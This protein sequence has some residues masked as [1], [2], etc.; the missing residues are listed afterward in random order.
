MK[1]KNFEGNTNQN[2]L[3]R[4]RELNSPITIEATEKVVNIFKKEKSTIM[5]IYLLLLKCTLKDG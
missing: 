5:W 3:I 4:D 2:D 1:Q